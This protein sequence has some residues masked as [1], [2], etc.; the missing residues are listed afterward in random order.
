MPKVDILEALRQSKTKLAAPSISPQT[1][2]ARATGAKL[3]ST[4]DMI[5]DTLRV[6][7]SR[8]QGES[9]VPADLVRKA[10][11]AAATWATLHGEMRES[12]QALKDE[13]YRELLA[14]LA[15]H[16]LPPPSP[17]GAPLAG[18]TEPHTN[19]SPAQT[20][21]ITSHEVVG[22]EGGGKSAGGGAAQYLEFD[23]DVG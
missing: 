12:I 23:D 14:E 10:R 19:F 3:M 6:E 4:L 15:A 8:A 16:A 17:L 18:A 22:D 2:D 11:D 1:L 13:E 9:R 7:V 5:A 20:S 21:L